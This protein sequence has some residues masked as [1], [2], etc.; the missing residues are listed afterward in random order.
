MRLL[1][2]SVAKNAT[3]PKW[4]VGCFGRAARTPATHHTPVLV[5][6]LCSGH[7]SYGSDS[8]ASGARASVPL[9]A[10]EAQTYLLGL[11]LSVRRRHAPS[12]CVSVPEPLAHTHLRHVAAPHVLHATPCA[13]P[14]TNLCADVCTTG[15]QCRSP[16]QAHLSPPAMSSNLGVYPWSLCGWGG[17][18]ESKITPFHILQLPKSPVSKPCARFDRHGVDYDFDHTLF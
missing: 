1:G 17:A 11:A 14:C 3:R 12:V 8:S 13:F 9:T 2:G 15:A 6:R 18:S 7:A 16:P 10:P 5:L 4:S